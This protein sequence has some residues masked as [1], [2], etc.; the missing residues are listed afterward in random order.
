MAEFITMLGELAAGAGMPSYR[1]LAK[2][3]GPL[4]KPPQVVAKTTISDLLKPGRR[5]LNLDLV[6]AVVRALGEDERT[7][8]RWRQACIRVHG[9]ST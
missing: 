7:V 8:D 6:V 3:V 9:A 4:L 2:R 1:E 5:R